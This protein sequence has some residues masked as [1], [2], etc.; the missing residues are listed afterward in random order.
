[1]VGSARRDSNADGSVCHAWENHILDPAISFVL[2]PQSE[3]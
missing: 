2:P 1:M 3:S